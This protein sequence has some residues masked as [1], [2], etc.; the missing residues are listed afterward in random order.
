[1]TI[2]TDADVIRLIRQNPRVLI[3]AITAHP[4]LLAEVRRAVLTDELL[5]MP[6]RLAEVV[7]TQA[8]ML[9]TQAELLESQAETRE[10]I[11]EML[12]TQNRML[13]E[14]A[15]ARRGIRALHRMYRRQREDF[16]KFR[17]YLAADAARRNDADIALHFSKR[18]GFNRIAMKVFTPTDINDFLN[19][20][21]WDIDALHLRER[22][23]RTFLKGD[24][25]AEVT[26]RMGD[27]PGFYLAVEASF[28]VDLEDLQ[29]AID[30]AKMLRAAGDLASYAVVAGVRMNDSV[31]GRL[32]KDVESFISAQDEDTA[33]W[34]PLDMKDLTPNP[35]F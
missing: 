34:F 12:K 22:A 16:G 33:L 21:Y 2:N 23:W 20:N 11:R 6:D 4:E 28:T 25:I 27:S 24:I 29:R 30:H 32:Y 19:E 10:T 15:N 3:D 35:P 5:A 8:E 13:E 14:Q 1:M 31:E 9:K 26:E 17:G 18:H 7:K